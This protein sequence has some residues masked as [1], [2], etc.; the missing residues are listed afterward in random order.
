MKPLE[1][2][3]LC[4]GDYC[5]WKDLVGN[6]A[7]PVFSLG[8]SKGML[9]AS[10]LLALLCQ[11]WQEGSGS[12][13]LQAFEKMRN[14][15]ACIYIHHVKHSTLENEVFH[16]FRTSLRGSIRKPPHMLTWVSVLSTL[17]GKGYEDS[18]AVIGRFNQ[19][20]AKAQQLIGS[21]A[22]AVG[23]LLFHLP[24]DVLSFLHTHV[25]QHGWEQCALSDDNLASKKILPNFVFKPVHK[26]WKPLCAMS[27]D[28]TK[29]IFRR[30]FAEFE[31]NPAAN[32]KLPKM[33]VD[34]IAESA[35]VLVN[36][37]KQLCEQFPIPMAHAETEI[38]DQWVA[39]H[40]G[41]ELEMH[42]I[43]A[44]KR[45]TLNVTDIRFFRAVVESHQCKIPVNSS[46][47][48]EIQLTQLDQDK[49]D[50]VMKQLDYDMAAFRTYKS[51]MENFR[52]SVHHTKVDWRRKRKE[53][54]NQWVTSWL[55][56][57]SSIFT[58]KDEQTAHL[59]EKV[60]E[61]MAQVI[62]NAGLKGSNTAPGTNTGLKF[63]FQERTHL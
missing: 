28:V 63:C 21:K 8:F 17:K 7:M 6:S 11:W 44:E 2:S 40:T 18:A 38:L 55:A 46:N 35:C 22:V 39:S 10:T 19:T 57:K 13:L 33:R 61:E 37:T 53:E 52:T 34:Q 14:S 43:M 45:A 41:L 32:R 5:L 50:L 16:N 15:L 27:I 58:Y 20:V 12:L 59:L 24:P 49:F 62:K 23:N 4:A 3:E 1:D 25:S 42:E 26:S 47:A 54:A 30:I 60:Q 56:K 29:L 48:V 51:K 9:R 31:G 36:L